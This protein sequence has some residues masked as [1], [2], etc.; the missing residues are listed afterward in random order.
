MKKTLKG[1]LI[2]GATLGVAAMSA[3]AQTSTATATGNAGGAAMSASMS[4][5]TMVSGTVN[6]YWTD[7]SGYVTAV[8]VQTANGSSVVHFSPGM[9]TRVMQMYPLGSSAN[10]WV[11]GSM[12]GGQQHW[13]LVGT[14]AAQPTTWWPINEASGLDWVAGGAFVNSNAQRVSVIGKLKRVVVDKH[15]SVVGLI[16]ETDRVVSGTVQRTLLRPDY[17]TDEAGNT[18]GMMASSTPSWTL[19]RVPPEFISAPNPHE[20]MDRK[21][22]LMLDDEIIAVGYMEAPR[23]GS[24]SQISNRLIASALSVNGRGVGAKGF[25]MYKP[26]QPTLFNFNINIPLIAGGDD[27][28][29]SVVPSGYET[30]SA[31]NSAA[32]MKK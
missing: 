20:G 26:N 23:Y 29:L 24:V 8:D 30:Y 32:M 25:P 15:G 1:C 19:V 9:A 21:T 10:L 13:D 27:A 3:N 11:Q 28:E 6:N 4:A 14:G 18:A 5:P 7:A 31:N 22:P 2:L 16:L 12:K 17:S